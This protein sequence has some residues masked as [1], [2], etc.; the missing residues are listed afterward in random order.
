ME[1][2]AQGISPIIIREVSFLKS[3]RH[4]NIIKIHD[5]VVSP[6]RVYLVLDHCCC[7][8]RN[9]MG[10][11]DRLGENMETDQVLSFSRQLLAAIA[12]CH[13]QR[14]IHRDIKPDNL[15]LD[16]GRRT[17]KLSDFGSARCLSTESICEDEGEGEK[18]RHTPGLVTLWYRAPEI[19]LGDTSYGLPVD[20]WGA[21]CTMAEMANLAP[22]FPGRSEVRIVAQ[23]FLLSNEP[24]CFSESLQ[25]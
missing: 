16:C 23:L 13:D 8:L 6:S 17:L 22:A 4:E 21:G 19:M 15:L 10:D 24:R 3:L 11:L 7:T 14:C 12:H 18:P 1:G 5:V 25:T 9:H 20:V 2:S